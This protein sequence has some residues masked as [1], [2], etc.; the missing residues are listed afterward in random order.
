MVRDFA[1]AL[2]ARKVSG[3]FEKQAPGLEAG[4]LSPESRELTT[5]PSKAQFLA[6]VH[7]PCRVNL[8]SFEALIA[9][10][11]LA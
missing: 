9:V 5:A 2:R 8:L 4:Q 7:L 3:A 10:L 6:L 11:K 1:M